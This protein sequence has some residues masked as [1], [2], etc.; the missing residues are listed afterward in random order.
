MICTMRYLI[1]VLAVL[2]LI[3]SAL[4]LHVHYSNAVEICDINAHWDCGIVNHS[5]YAEIKHVPVAVLG[6]AGYTAM[7]VL[8]LARRRK[9]LTLF[10][11]GGLCF[12][13]YLSHIEADVL[14]VWCLYCVISQAIIALIF[15]ISL[16]DTVRAWRRKVAEASGT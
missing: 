2:G 5:R 11:L 15:V 1:A 13:L 4:A 3:V 9:V 6:I 8:A 10:A 12:A 16:V 7:V 14:Q